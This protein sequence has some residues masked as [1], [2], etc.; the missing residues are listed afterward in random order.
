MTRRS[1]R[2]AWLW[3]VLFA[4]VWVTP[5]GAQ[6]SL[7]DGE[8]SADG[9]QFSVAPY[10]WGVMI[11]GDA[12]IAG[13]TTSVD[14][15]IIEII[16]DSDSIVALQGHFEVMKGNFGAYVDG[17]YMD[18]NIK[19]NVGPVDLDTDTQV[20]LADF[21]AFYRVLDRPLDA[22]PSDDEDRRLN[23]DVIAGARY[24]SLEVD[25]GVSAG[26]ISTT[27]ENGK[28]WWDPIV[29]GRIKYDLT[30]RL[31]VFSRSDIGGF[32][33]GSDFTWSGL[34]MLGYRF[35]LFGAPAMVLGGYRALYTDYEE[36]SGLNKFAWD[37]WIH[38]PIIGLNVRF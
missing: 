4:A 8:V 23:V 21:T 29:G 7:P 11:N 18:L 6:E 17:T 9:W 35:E 5:A 26:G 38:G 37:I 16:E 34:G 33:A 31:F 24:T 25:L 13:A 27:L 1:Y 22:A 12:T 15:N 32:G 19:S 2:I 20:I 28:N 14:T 10:V 30:D 3:C 36:G